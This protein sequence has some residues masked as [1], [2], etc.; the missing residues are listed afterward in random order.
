ME[1]KHTISD[2]EIKRRVEKYMSHLSFLNRDANS[3]KILFY[4]KKHGEEGKLHAHQLNLK[5]DFCS[6][7]IKE[8]RQKPRLNIEDYQ[9]RIDNKFLN[10]ELQNNYFVTSLNNNYLTIHC[11]KHKNTFNVRATNISYT[12][13]V[14]CKSCTSERITSAKIV[15]NNEVID[16]LSQFGFKDEKTKNQRKYT[17]IE[18]V[19]HKGLL[20]IKYYC[21]QHKSV[22]FQSITFLKKGITSCDGC[23]TDKK[24]KAIKTKKS[25][26]EFVENGKLIHGNIFKYPNKN[27]QASDYVNVKTTFDVECTNCGRFF[28]TNYIYHITRKHGCNLCYNEKIG[29]KKIN[30]FLKKNRYAFDREKFIENTNQR[31]DFYIH[32]INTAIEFDGKQHFMP[33][34]FFGGEKEFLKTKS[35]DKIKDE[36]CMSNKIGLI[37]I[38]FDKLNQIDNILKETLSDELLKS[39]LIYKF[40]QYY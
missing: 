17:F 33:V 22:N 10:T 24:R 23:K 5:Q 3:R 36:Y 30:E 37:R 18:R 1:K 11:K 20:K 8:K 35:R 9:K 2:D 4:C 32:K 34:D 13:G 27:N 16:I 7:C 40:G 28:K 38:G 39:K 21:N 25:Y 19:R 26:K 31:F 12:S 6:E 29:E 14:N 15:E